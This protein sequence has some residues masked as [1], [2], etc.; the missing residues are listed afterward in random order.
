MPDAKKDFFAELNSIIDTANDQL[1]GSA[2]RIVFRYSVR[3]GLHYRRNDIDDGLGQG[4]PAVPVSQDVGLRPTKCGE[5]AHYWLLRDIHRVPA[6]DRA[7]R[8]Q[9]YH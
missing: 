5:T 2:G 4:M 3:S 8:A 1:S 7:N 9:Q 6:D